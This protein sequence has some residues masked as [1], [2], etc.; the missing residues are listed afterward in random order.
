MSFKNTGK[1]LI[2]EVPYGMYVWETTRDGETWIVQDD[3]ANVM[4]VFAMKGDREAIRAITEAAAYYGFPH[5]RAV[6]WSGRRR[7]TD[8]EL[9]EQLLRQQWGLEP[10]P[11]N[12]P[13]LVAQAKEQKAHGK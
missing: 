8:E 13:A 5:G 11:Q 2:E 9:D 12:Y 10:D 6:F 4:N 7:I 1:Q 3:D